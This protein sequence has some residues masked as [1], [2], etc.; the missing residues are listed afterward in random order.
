MHIYAILY[1]HKCMGEQIARFLSGKSASRRRVQCGQQVG[2][3]GFK[4]ANRLDDDDAAPIGWRKPENWSIY[5]PTR[6]QQVD[7]FARGFTSILFRGAAAPAAA[8]IAAGSLY[9]YDGENG[10][11]RPCTTLQAQAPTPGLD[12]GAWTPLKLKEV[13]Q[14]TPNTAI[15]RFAFSDPA[16]PSGMPVASCVVTKANI[17][18]EKPDGSRKPVIRPYTPISRPESKGY[19]DLA[20]KAYPDGK[21][22]KHIASL[23]VGDTLD[24]KGPIVKLPYKPNQY[25]SVGMIAGGTG[26]AP[27]LQVVDEILENPADKTKVSL[28][29]ANVSED[30]IILK[31]Q[32]DA[33]AKAHPSRFSVYYVVDKPK[34]ASSWTGGVGYVTKD[35]IK[36]HIPAPSGKTM[37]FVCGPPPMYAAISGKKGTAEN[38]KAQGELGGILKGMG[39]SSENVFKF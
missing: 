20:V 29:F 8:A 18:E 33:K 12:P 30:D 31:D 26:I 37:V 27:M 23:K 17:G 22:S 7:M 4:L 28:I 11:H 19:V 10:F 25:T 38:P 35:M 3:W 21:M 34:S 5:A 1:K 32:I 13:K 16:A 15:Y 9:S 2:P 39:Y 24:M 6:N 14:L 36:A